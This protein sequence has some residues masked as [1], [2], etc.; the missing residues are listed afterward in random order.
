MPIVENGVMTGY[1]D[2]SKHRPI[3]LSKAEQTKFNWNDKVN[4]EYYN[5]LILATPPLGSPNPSGTV[6]IPGKA[7]INSSNAKSKVNSSGSDRP[8]TGTPNS[9]YNTAKGE[10]VFVYDGKGKLIY[11]LSG[12]R[13]KAFN[14]NVNPITGKEFYQPYKL[15]GPVPQNIKNLFGW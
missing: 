8:I 14:I 13:V 9:Y 7:L 3:A 1:Y 6:S 4:A 11:D 15:I 2:E 12:D 5:D 10:H